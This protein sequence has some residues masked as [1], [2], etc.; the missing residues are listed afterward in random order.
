MRHTLNEVPHGP[1]ESE[2]RHRVTSPGLSDPSAQGSRQRLLRCTPMRAT[3]ERPTEQTPA[4]NVAFRFRRPYAERRLFGVPKSAFTAGLE[5]TPRRGGQI[6]CLENYRVRRVS[7]TLIR[8]MAKWDCCSKSCGRLTGVTAIDLNIEGIVTHRSVCPAGV[9]GKQDHQRHP[10]V[11]EGLAGGTL[12]A[13][14][15][16]VNPR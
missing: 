4:W 15:G 8:E 13:T 6:G 7:G 1:P 2:S 16:G 12:L 3:G 11:R 5:A 10:P 14:L 9:G